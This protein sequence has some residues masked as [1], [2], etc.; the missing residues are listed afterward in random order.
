MTVETDQL[1]DRI[2]Q[3]NKS[4]PEFR[5]HESTVKGLKAEVAAANVKIGVSDPK[6]TAAELSR[7]VERYLDAW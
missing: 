2:E 4:M 6:V 7:L 1:L 5:T 3:L